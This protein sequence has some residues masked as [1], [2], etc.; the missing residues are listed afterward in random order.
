[1]RGKSKHPVKMST[2][3]GEDGKKF[4]E[5]FMTVGDK[6][7]IERDDP[8]QIR[9]RYNRYL[10]YVF[11]MK[12]GK[13]VN[14]N[15][16]CVRAGWSPYFMKYGYSRRFDQE[17][18]QAQDEA[19][20]AK[21]GIWQDGTQHYPDYPERLAWWTARGDFVAEF[22]KDAAGHD[23]FIDLTDWDSLD[24]IENHLG[25]QVTL[26]GTI[27]DI[28]LGDRGPTRVMLSRQMHSDFPL[29]FFDKDVFGNT[30]LDDYKGEFI[31]ARGTVT[32]YTNKHTGRTNVQ[33]VIDRPSQITLPTIPGIDPPTVG[34]PATP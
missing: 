32:E 22:A 11:V 23:D 21:R 7:R 12:N 34:G 29:V 19:R 10:A 2:P 17:F 28:R 13:W 31:R 5:S 4:A 26:L 9:D 20:A 8:R 33:I 16:E 24:R 3:V 14:Y 27:G 6:V 1:M 25:K 30:H 18:R 15:V